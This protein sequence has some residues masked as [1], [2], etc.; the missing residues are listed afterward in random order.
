MK[1][2]LLSFLLLSAVSA[3]QAAGPI[4]SDND[5]RE[6]AGFALGLTADQ[7]QVTNVRA[8]DNITVKFN[9]NARGRVFQC[10]Y[11]GVGT[12]TS[13][14]ICSPTDGKPMP[15]SAACNDLLRASGNCQ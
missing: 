4:I 12:N 14:A 10:Y 8:T 13:D 15:A 3:A 1:K 7:V 6:K 5:I 11:Q 9:A 2:A